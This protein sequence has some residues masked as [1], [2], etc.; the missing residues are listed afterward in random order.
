MGVEKEYCDLESLTQYP[1]HHV[2]R[3]SGLP[4]AAC[5]LFGRGMTYTQPSSVNSSAAIL[6]EAEVVAGEVGLCARAGLAV[7]EMMAMSAHKRLWAALLLDEGVRC[8]RR[9]RRG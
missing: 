3:P 6:M 9:V 8:V 1:Y 2:V 7:T 4:Q 5:G